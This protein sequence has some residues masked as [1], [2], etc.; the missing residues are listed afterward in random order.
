MKNRIYTL[1]FITTTIFLVSCKQKT[2]EESS[3]KVIPVKTLN[4]VYSDH[5]GERSYVGVTEG[6]LSVS[7]SFSSN[8]TVERVLATEGQR[9]SKGQLL[10]VLSNGTQKN[11]YEFALSTLKQ[12]QDAYDRISMLHQKGSTTDIQFVEVETGLEKA[13][14][15][16]EIAKKN[17]DDCNLYAPMNGVIATRNIE[18]GSNVL[19]GVSVL[20]LVTINDMEVKVS[21]PEN[22][23]GN[24][25]VGQNATIQVSA[26]NNQIYKGLVQKKGVEANPVLHTYE[27]KIKLLS[28]LPD[29]LPGMVCK[30]FIGEDNNQ[31]NIVIPNKSVNISS[32][33]QSFVWLAINNIATRK[34][35]TTG[36]LTDYGVVVKEGLDIGDK[37]II[38]GTSK[39]SEGM[40]ISEIQ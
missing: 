40:Q 38:E 31:K 13:K 35:I 6:A 33:G 17:L 4:I 34:F 27:V 9:V 2:T 5:T 37:L 10:A 23:I 22:E 8:G 3:S 26:L 7:L 39:I 11:A 19:P 1:L 16:S 20:K 18:A 12:A 36:A 25:K 15:M 24:I 32:D 29:I 21:I 14:A 30:V 28:S